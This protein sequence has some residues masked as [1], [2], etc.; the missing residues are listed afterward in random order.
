MDY[1]H[2]VGWPEAIQEAEAIGRCQKTRSS[3]QTQW[4]KCLW[5]R[6]ALGISTDLLQVNIWNE[7]RQEMTFIISPL[8]LE[9][10]PQ[11]SG[12]LWTQGFETQPPVPPWTWTSEVH[13]S[14]YKFWLKK[15]QQTCQMASFSS[16]FLAPHC[17]SNGDV[18]QAGHCTSMF[19][20][21]ATLPVLQ[22]WFLTFSS[23]IFLLS[24]R[25]N[26]FRKSRPRETVRDRVWSWN[27]FSSSN[28]RLDLVVP[29]NLCVSLVSRWLRVTRIL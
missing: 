14:I 11:T 20:Q 12:R 18:N 6:R 15:M 23:A 16:L 29:S 9:P 10:C 8:P 7:W 4:E 25:G 26:D 19:Y 5:W 22:R 2:P 21:R 13:R 1:A 17:S 28:P 27:V 24:S 3:K